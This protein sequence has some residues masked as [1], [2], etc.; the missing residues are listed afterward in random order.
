MAQLD[1]PILPHYLYR[2]RPLTDRNLSREI[3]AIKEQYIWLSTYR[4]LNDPMEGFYKASRGLK[5]DRAFDKV[6]QALLS[7]KADV[8]ICS[9]SDTREDELMWAHYASNYAGI[10]VAYRPRYLIDGLPPEI[11]LIRLGYGLTPPRI[12]G[13]EADDL[14]IAVRKVL[15][16]KKSNWGSEREWRVLGAP[17]Q[18]NIS[19]KG[20]IKEVYLGARIKLHHREKIQQE[21]EQTKIRVYQM[22]R[23]SNYSIRWERVKK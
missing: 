17:G 14:Q 4:A 19:S 6:T 15:S 2:Y 22:I 7:A 9:F 23:V 3:D 8:G 12:S 10:C 1:S 21:L 13:L 11:H 18:L 16:H 5:A 20:C